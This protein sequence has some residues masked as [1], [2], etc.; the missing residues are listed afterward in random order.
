MKHLCQYITTL[1]A[2]CG[3]SL[4]LF[5]FAL[6]AMQHAFGQN[7]GQ[8]LQLNGGQWATMTVGGNNIFDDYT[9]EAWVRPMDATKTM[10][11]FSTRGVPG[12]NDYG[13]KGFDMKLQGGNTIHADVPFLN[14][15]RYGWANTAADVTYKYEVGHWYHIAYQVSGPGRFIKIYVNGILQKNIQ[16]SFS[17]LTALLFDG[18][19]ATGYIGTNRG[20]S[21]T[22]PEDFIGSIDE[23][24]IY[25]ASNIDP[26][27]DAV[28]TGVNGSAAYYHFDN[29]TA[30]SAPA[31]TNAVLSGSPVYVQSYAMQHLTAYAP[32]NVTST[33][34]TAS[35]SLAGNINAN[36]YKVDVASDASFTQPTT[37]TF[38]GDGITSA[39]VTGLPPGLA[40]YYRVSANNT[41]TAVTGQGAYS[42]TVWPPPAITS[43]TPGN[44]MAGQG[45]V[46]NGKNFK[47]VTSVKFG[48]TPSANFYALST[49]VIV[50]TVPNGSS[51]NVTVTTDYG[52]ATAG[53]FT[54]NSAFP[55]NFTYNSPNVLLKKVTQASISPAIVGSGGITG[56]T[57]MS[58]INHIT[59]D[60]SGN[61]FFSTPTA[62]YKLST[63]GDVT[64]LA[65]ISYPNGLATDPSGNLYVSR[66]NN[67][68]QVGTITKITP[69]GAVTTL[70]SGKSG[71]L[72][73]DVLGN[74]YVANGGIYKINTTTGA[75]T[76]IW[77]DIVDTFSQGIT[78]VTE[79]L[80]IDGI[81]NIY[82]VANGL[83]S[84]AYSIK[85]LALDGSFTTIAN[86][87]YTPTEISCD[88]LGNL[89]LVMSGALYKIPAGGTP[90]QVDLSQYSSLPA[91]KTVNAVAIGLNGSLYIDAVDDILYEISGAVG[92]VTNY[93]ITPALP[94]GLTLN[95]A[96]GT[97]SGIPA[98]T[99]TLKSYKVTANNSAGSKAA[100][101]QI[102]VTDI[103]PNSFSYGSP[104]VFTK[105]TAIN[106]LTPVFLNATSPQQTF[107]THLSNYSVAADDNY[108][109]STD[110]SS[111]T[112]T[113]RL[114]GSTA[115][116][117]SGF[118]IAQSLVTDRA[119]NV[120]LVDR[121]N[122]AIKKITPAGVVTKVADVSTNSGMIID[123]A[124]YLYVVSTSASSAL[125]KISPA[126]VVTNVGPNIPNSIG[127]I[128][129]N[130]LDGKIYCVDG[131]AGA[132][133][134]LYVEPPGGGD[135]SVIR[136]SGTFSGF[137]AQAAFDPYGNL[138][139]A[140]GSFSVIDANGV[141]NKFINKPLN[142]LAVDSVGNMFTT[143]NSSI[144]TM[145]PATGGMPLN[146][147]I[148]PALPDGLSINTTT[149]IISGTSSV[150]SAAT[151]YTITASNNK[152]SN[153]STVTIT[154]NDV[155]PTAVSYASS[156][157]RFFKGSVVSSVAPFSTGGVPTSYTISPALPAG[158]LFDV[159]TG[160]ISGTPTII[161]PAIN[162][163]VTAT[164]ISGNASCTVTI[165][166]TYPVGTAIYV[167]GA[168]GNDA[169]DGSGSFS[170][171]F[172]TL[173]QAL[174]VASQ[175]IYVAKV[176]VAGG[177]YYPA[178]TAAATTSAPDSAFALTRNGLRLYGGYNATTGLRDINANKT[179]MD[180][181]N[182]SYHILAIAGI[183]A[184]DSVI[185]DGITIQRAQVTGGG[186][187]HTYN[188]VGFNRD[189]GAGVAIRSNSGL[190][191][192]LV[193]RNCAFINNTTTNN[194]AAVYISQSSPVFVS[195]LFA[196]NTGKSGTMFCYDH[197]YPRLVNCTFAN[198][199]ATASSAA[200]T[201]VGSST[202]EIDNSI[203]WLNTTAGSTTNSALS[204]DGPPSD[205]TINNS[206]IQNAN[207]AFDPMFLSPS[208][209]NYRLAYASRAINAGS[210]ALYVGNINSDIDIDGKTRLTGAKLDLGAYETGSPS[211]TLYVDAAAGNDAND[212]ST[213]VKAFKTLSTALNAANINTGSYNVLV[214]KGTYYPAGDVAATTA[215]G[216]SA[217]AITHNGIRLYGGYNATTGVRDINANKTYLD[218]N[219]SSYH[220][221]AIAGIGAG[222][223]VIVD[224]ITIQNANSNGATG[225]T[226]NGQGFNGN[227]GGGVS[228]VG[229]NGLGNKLLFRN[230]AFINNKGN[231]HAAA[232]YN[233]ESS[234]SFVSCLFANNTDA[235]DGSMLFNWSNS[236]PVFTN[237]TITYNI[238][239]G[240]GGII[241]S[242]GGSVPVFNNS[243]IWLNGTSAGANNSGITNG[244]TANNSIIQG[245][246]GVADPMFVNAAA[247]NYRLSYASPAINAGNSVL[248]AGNI[249]NDVDIEGKARLIGTKPDMG[250]YE[251]S[252]PSSTIYVDDAA[253]N[254]ANDGSTWAKA[255]KTVSTALNAANIITTGSYKILVAKGTY[256]PAGDAA[257]T[258][259]NKDSS[260]AIMHNSIRL[261]GG[262]DATTGLRNPAINKTYLDGNNSSIHILAIAGIGAGD[263][264]I[265][266]GVT[267]QHAYVN[268]VG[269]GHTYNGIG[270]NYDE[271]AG[272]AIRSNSGLGNML[273]FRN[274]AFV[275]N[276]TSNNGAAVYN[277]LSSPTFVNCLF[278]NNSGRSG[279]IFNYD[280]CKP[281]IVNCTFA[282]N[283]VTADGGALTNLNVTIPEIDN[284]I[285]WLN[286]TSAGANNSGI[287]N[288]GSSSVTSSNNIIQG[289]NADPLFTNAASGNY[290][291]SIGSPAVNGGSNAAYIGYINNDL[292]LDGKPRLTGSVIDIGAYETD[293]A[294]SGLSYAGSPFIFIKGTAITPKSP[295]VSGGT[296]TNYS[297][298]P[299][300]PAGLT[301][302]ATTGVISGNA[303]AV[304]AIADYIIKAANSGGSATTTISI[305]VNDAAPSALSYAGAPF[306]FTNGVTI[307]PA[308]PSVSGGTVTVYSVTPALPAGLSINTSTGVISGTPTAIALTADYIVKATN[309]TGNTTATVSITVNDVAP[310][311][312]SYAGS[313]FTYTKGTTIT[314]VSPSIS[315]GAV[316]G[317]SVTP[318][319][320][321]GL[322]LNTATGVI[323]GN[324]TV[325]ASTASYTVK[326][327][328][329]GGNATAI[330]SITVKDVA[331]AALSY[332][333]APFIFKKG[334][335]ITAL[336]PSVSGGTVTN[337]SITPT[338][339][340]GIS[341]DAA[342]GIIS[343][344]PV[345]TVHS[346]T[347]TVTATNSGG[348]KSTAFRLYVYELAPGDFYYPGA[349]STLNV[350]ADVTLTPVIKPAGQVTTVRAI[351]NGW[352]VV[353]DNNYIYTISTDEKA[354]Y[355]IS[356]TDNTV[357][358]IAP[359]IP[360]PM[361]V[362][363]DASTGNLYVTDN[364]ATGRLWKIT[365]ANVVTVFATGLGYPGIITTDAA[366]NIYVADANGSNPTYR[367]YKIT[368]GGTKTTF[369]TVTDFAYSLAVSPVTGELYVTTD[370]AGNIVKKIA[371]SGGTATNATGELP[372]YANFITFD[373]Q[374][375]LL[376]A[377]YDG[378]IY[379]MSPAG[380]ISTF[381]DGVVE[382][383]VIAA[384][385]TGDIYY[386]DYATGSL[387]KITGA[388][389]MA[390]QYT[391]TPALPAGLT[392]NSGTGV[393][394][395]RPVTTMPAT[396]YTV[397]AVND[398]GSNAT[399]LALTVTN[400]I[401]W[402][403]AT[404]TNWNDATN[405]STNTVPTATDDVSI[406]TAPPNQ[407][408]VSTAATA[409]SITLGGILKVDAAGTLSIAG[410]VTSTGTFNAMA[411]TLIFNGTD[412][413]TVQG[414]IIVKN[415]TISNTSTGHTAGV[416]LYSGSVKVY[417]TYTP[418]AGVLNSNG[419]L[420]LASNANGT[421][422]VAN[423][424]DAT[425]Y[426]TGNVTVERY[427][428]AKRA[429]RLLTAPLSQTGTIF[430]NW[431][432][433]G[434]KDDTTGAEIFSPAG[435][436]SA[437]N[438]LTKAG[439]AASVKTYNSSIDD[440]DGLTNTTATSLGNNNSS[441][442]NSA[443][444]I[445]ITGPYRSNTITTA[446]LN[447]TLRAT[448]LLQTGTQT[449]NYS[450]NNGQY[451]LTGNPYAAPIDFKTITKTNVANTMWAWDAQLSTLGGYV[452]FS[453][454]SVKDKYDQDIAPAL[455]KQTRIIQSG[456][457]F[458]VQATANSQTVTIN[459]SDK[460]S[461]DSSRNT[462]FFAPT[463]DDAQQL[464][465]TL[466]KAGEG[467]DGILVKL[468]NVYKQD[469]TD[470]GNK[471]FSYNENLSIR[472]DTSYLGIERMPLP[473]ENDSL[474]LD[475]W[476]MKAKTSYSFTMQPQNIPVKVK[477]YLLDR[478]LN[479]KTPLSL[480]TDSTLN[481]T[482]TSDKGSYAEDRFVIVFAQAGALASTGTTVK[483]LQQGSDVQV[484]WVTTN[485]YDVQ[486][487]VIERS[488]DG[489]HFTAMQSNIQPR[490]SG[491]TEV[492]TV[493]DR[494]PSAGDNYYR[495][496]IINK[497]GS[498]HYSNTAKV[499]FTKGKAVVSVYPNP[500]VRTE[501]LYITMTNMDAGKY[502]IQLFSSDGKQVIQKSMQYD[503]SAATQG[504]NLPASIAAGSYR[505][506]V[507]DE[508]GNTWKQQV[509]IQ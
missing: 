374:G 321:G 76:V 129:I 93:S 278:A 160:A 424:G 465:I 509:I 92:P 108:I 365:P 21:T 444:G 121:N 214:A 167:D 36:E 270:F 159:N 43:F 416:N 410:N 259:G 239:T 370:Y 155:A 216:D 350:G 307:T 468:D 406:P 363:L 145:T 114:T 224:G 467:I 464:R 496:Q 454:D 140:A 182:S 412:S 10:T 111:V 72:A 297:V 269:A 339:P 112:K 368:P 431:Q 414:V 163:T 26:A 494:Q 419:H 204:T 332:T 291:L 15:N 504:I 51:G 246:T 310:S 408:I 81:G 451:I 142:G 243:I 337:Y 197:C 136:L 123:T 458:F 104:S 489:L 238:T 445:F 128:A 362:A 260:F 248:Y 68:D 348:N 213:W 413:Q 303:T 275:N 185:V 394:S 262:Y 173:G 40:Y 264:V 5:C 334:I 499:I 83:G 356:K 472:V 308:S 475:V 164:N 433:G 450:V 148:S 256:Y 373:A 253:G 405:W 184:G 311:N 361:V 407:P 302:N 425:G 161:T 32:T 218:G 176:L 305:T 20:Y 346:K 391:I 209:G 69:A 292:A 480:T 127:G 147:S 442:A 179:Y 330:I 495:V 205:I 470:D 508:K 23:V 122:N 293:A 388:G 89:Y 473:K 301:L 247:G 351:S 404:S 225:H 383:N 230:C 158:L 87:S 273:L 62:V 438:G 355:K 186:A 261:Y 199:V 349:S 277:S 327:A 130:P 353:T 66:Q 322:T 188:G 441:A 28:S 250:A 435:T 459:E 241:A 372:F 131:G 409:H 375:N 95:A 212:G 75:V 340:A 195:C 507:L 352:G 229:N 295:T 343:G 116:I 344:T 25:N 109:Y 118:N 490:N 35:W 178:G 17:S 106:A 481:F 357:T 430:N 96:N 506:I 67:A 57:V 479:T 306:V 120:Y 283:I 207:T 323:S 463:T 174:Q 191:N 502:T 70:V 286:G 420:V 448:G 386:N 77:T 478:F 358:R 487:Y 385:A 99:L 390:K 201:V 180:G 58:V 460:A 289:I 94:A 456:Q 457:A 359:E 139:V 377:E 287:T 175:H 13:D 387:L 146:Y 170:N 236:N 97:I 263:S 91:N 156:L 11:I 29:S 338:L 421:A 103:K 251:T 165:Q 206:I 169:N 500:V 461:I 440:W 162:Y 138:L 319:L 400:L 317:Y 65:S 320:P 245:T 200:I 19:H 168:N 347:Y 437:G 39:V 371:A 493:T 85:K 497:D 426:I 482:T 284:T 469:L 126:G 315:G 231:N 215:N 455:T 150:P 4:V 101:V 24:K 367:I 428:P 285:I 398:A 63:G 190:G 194:G 313:P 422:A 403:G 471:L 16:Q 342:T 193:F 244:A 429:W 78:L 364:T 432:N 397:A 267:I 227:E 100:T 266:D 417:G 2:G 82:F 105:G 328:N 133:A 235:A 257:T 314:L 47:N 183:G 290:T 181:N 384:D 304:A 8:A 157:Y 88:G 279:T 324:P 144:I 211:S 79:R 226:Y 42:N 149:G 298:T 38:S 234:P 73:T 45:I 124:G 119:G 488:A 228:A 447:T 369:S 294:P 449:F 389:G 316:T 203:I 143:T 242:A 137:P 434:V 476:G 466:N 474:W 360:N 505:L 379:S 312:L 59:T 325:V 221:L 210:S 71:G 296:V 219:N 274:C 341:I 9:V 282:N 217:F 113:S 271:G 55:G 196:G 335:A 381:Y 484:E 380:A 501:K 443:Y 354:V 18:T 27:A 276:V 423:A 393:I 237:C 486:Q 6:F 396:T 49:D 268:G 378:H 34:F 452:M 402:T 333:G 102:G 252:L 427:I 326:A 154:V 254:D 249:S 498:I 37:L 265:V 115:V 233:N 208:T 436:G 309:G 54:L 366:G 503:G 107:N 7:P 56:L 31:G 220:V 446:P 255:F 177:T 33:G 12:A 453:Y 288:D 331:P 376:M 98:D 172:K 50:A 223:S 166:V 392:L 90:G 22:T 132:A 30:T 258:A 192:M 48:G 318:A 44:A 135:T 280:H 477:A 41:A 439:V 64:K 61:V 483:A 52:T 60:Y 485:E 86:V 418:T 462:V 382:T 232:F 395:G 14:V 222:D 117:A 202:P 74:L 411:G 399:Q 336:S 1:A 151:N 300:L 3:K 281:L 345:D 110:R 152:G 134:S 415:L 299:A 189:E 46:I 401:T 491:R 240:S 272:V 141:I 187:G 198:N 492:Y 329:S 80:A 153:T 171:A 53:G 84:S 125:I